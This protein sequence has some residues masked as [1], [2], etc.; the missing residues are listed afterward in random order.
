MK[1]MTPSAMQVSTI[2]FREILFFIVAS[3]RVLVSVEHNA[4][5]TREQLVASRALKARCAGVCYAL[6]D[7]ASEMA[8]FISS[9]SSSNSR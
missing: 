8:F 5:H 1:A 3:M 6:C 9:S 7:N 4:R 2:I